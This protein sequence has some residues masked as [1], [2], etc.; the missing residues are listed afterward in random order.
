MKKEVLSVKG[1]SCAHCEGRINS[2]LMAL[3]GV[4][5]CK[6][7]AKKEK[8]SLKYDEAVISLQTIRENITELGYEVQ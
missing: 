8:V 6:A 5:E 1:M 3:S 7:E 4:K 2:A